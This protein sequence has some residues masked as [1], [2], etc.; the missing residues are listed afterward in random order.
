MT[1]CGFPPAVPAGT[2]PR[3]AG[4]CLSI[5]SPQRGFSPALPERGGDGGRARHLQLKA[6]FGLV[7]D[8]LFHPAAEAVGVQST[9]LTCC[10]NEHFV[11]GGAVPD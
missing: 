6:S 7:P 5:I 1:R 3:N 4:R 9:G 11:T 2:E 10:T 8:K